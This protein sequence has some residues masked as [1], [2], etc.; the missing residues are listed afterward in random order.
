MRHLL[1][2]FYS[3]QSR[4]LRRLRNGATPSS[5]LP[6]HLPHTAKAP[7]LW[8]P[9]KIRALRAGPLVKS[10]LRMSRFRR[11]AVRLPPGFVIPVAHV[12]LHAPSAMR[13]VTPRL[14]REV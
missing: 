12:I 11:S 2:V 3:A 5:L 8:T 14:K 13:Q 6:R 1:A 9:P 10:A 4:R 7:R